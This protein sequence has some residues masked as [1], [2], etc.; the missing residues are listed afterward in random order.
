MSQNL[1][2]IMPYTPLHAYFLQVFTFILIML[3]FCTSAFVLSMLDFF[4]FNSIFL[5]HL[6]AWYYFLSLNHLLTINF[7]VKFVLYLLH[8][9]THLCPSFALS[10][11]IQPLLNLP[12]VPLP[13]HLNPLW[14]H[15][16]TVWSVDPRCFRYH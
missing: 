11:S 1:A 13:S 15:Y 8:S 10:P 14:G 7:F 2:M 12:A 16:C 3:H 9:T 5:P 6:S 4:M